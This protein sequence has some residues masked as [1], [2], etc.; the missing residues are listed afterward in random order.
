MLG[1]F[2]PVV[3]TSEQDRRAGE[4]YLKIYCR[5][6]SLLFVSAAEVEAEASV[7]VD[8]DTG[9]QFKA[10]LTLISSFTKFRF[11]LHKT[12]AGQLLVFSVV[13]W[14]LLLCLDATA[15]KV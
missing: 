12:T 1:V 15:W 4:L 3:I 7:L 8:R 10:A 9:F 11:R 13:D 2:Q 5:K 6:F 14:E